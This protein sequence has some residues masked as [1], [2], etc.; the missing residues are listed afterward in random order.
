MDTFLNGKKLIII[1]AAFVMILASAEAAYA[2]FSYYVRATGYARVR[3]APETEI[4]EEVTDRTKTVSVRNT[5]EKDRS[6]DVVVRVMVFGPDGIST[7][8][9]V[10]GDWTEFTDLDGRKGYYYNSILSPGESTSDIR[11]SIEGLTP[12]ADLSKFDVIVVQEAAAAVT[13]DDGT[14]AAPDGWAGFPSIKG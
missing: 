11:A 7:A 13:G 1:L 6:A 3:L 14:V 10:P 4:D 9:A 5:G 12:D 8:P 2:Y